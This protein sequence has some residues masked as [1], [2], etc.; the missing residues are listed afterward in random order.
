M[1]L[2][3]RIVVC[4]RLWQRGKAV[5]LEQWVGGSWPAGLVGRGVHRHPCRL[6]RE[7]QLWGR[8]MLCLQLL[9]EEP[10]GA[11]LL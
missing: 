8:R 3:Q 6:L 9:L 2:Q 10:W 1:G 5:G 11:L 4:V 7:A